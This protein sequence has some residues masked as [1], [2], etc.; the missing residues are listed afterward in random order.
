MS[1]K[2]EH[3][4]TKPFYVK[5]AGKVSIDNDVKILQETEKAI[6]I[7]ERISKE[8]T[9][10]SKTTQWIAKSMILK[11]E[12]ISLD[13]ATYLKDKIDRHDQSRESLWR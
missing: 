1:V 9:M 8:D 2:Y 10:F 7:S 3:V 4:I 6:L 5:Y 12:E 13:H 11:R